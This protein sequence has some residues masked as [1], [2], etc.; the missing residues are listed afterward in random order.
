MFRYLPERDLMSV[1]EG[2]E[3]S[4]CISPCWCDKWC[5]HV[6][7]R[8]VCRHPVSFMLMGL[9]LISCA[10]T[11]TCTYTYMCTYNCYQEYIGNL[12]LML[13]S[14]FVDYIGDYWAHW[15]KTDNGIRVSC[16]DDLFPTSLHLCQSVSYYRPNIWALQGLTL[17]IIVRTFHMF[18]CCTPLIVTDA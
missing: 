13:C 8:T 9:F 17:G 4:A 14:R 2:T 6:L 7:W 12:C 18:C 1:M 15:Q 11:C 10:C 5:L 3:R 16:N